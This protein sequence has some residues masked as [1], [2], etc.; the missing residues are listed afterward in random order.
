MT[1]TG[2][3]IALMIVVILVTVK[4][5]MTGFVTEFFSKAAVIIGTT[6][7][8]LFYRKLTTHIVRLIGPDSL[9]EVI[10]FLVIFLLLYLVVKIIQQLLGSAIEGETMTNLDRAL[11]FF[12]GIGEG[13]LLIIVILLLVE[14]QPWFDLGTLTADSMFASLLKPVITGSKGFISGLFPILD[15]K[16]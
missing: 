7:A 16:K 13:V 5:T 3:D 2:F 6:G 1:F 12:L 8:I 4:V 11:G 15:Y 9:S 14:K 10:S